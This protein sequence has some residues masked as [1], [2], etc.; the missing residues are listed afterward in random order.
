MFKP[1]PGGPKFEVE[2]ERLQNLAGG[3]DH[4][5]SDAV[6]RDDADSRFIPL[7]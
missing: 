6:T 4:L 7:P 2:I 5:L 3:G 1:C